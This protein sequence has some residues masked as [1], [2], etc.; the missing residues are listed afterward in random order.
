MRRYLVKISGKKVAHVEDLSFLSDREHRYNW[1]QR[2]YYNIRFKRACR[3]ADRIIASSANVADDIAKY[4]L[5]PRS[6]IIIRQ[7]TDKR[8]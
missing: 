8:R 3:K 4:Y 5:I 2:H 1:L 6:K 7:N